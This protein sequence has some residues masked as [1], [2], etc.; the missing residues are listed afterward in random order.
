VLQAYFLNITNL[1]NSEES[2]RVRLVQ[3]EPNTLTS[4][5]SLRNNNFTLLDT[6][7]LNNAQGVFVIDNNPAKP[8]IYRLRNNPIDGEPIGN[9][10]KI[11]S[12]GTAKLAVF[13]EIP[14]DDDGNIDFDAANYE[15]RGHVE[16]EAIGGFSPFFN[17]PVDVLLTPQNRA[18]FFNAG[19]N[20]TNQLQSSLPT[21]DGGA[22]QQ[23]P[24]S[25]PFL[26][27]EVLD[28]PVFSQSRDIKS[29]IDALPK[30]PEEDRTKLL[31]SLLE[32]I[33]KNT[34]DGSIA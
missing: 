18:T 28:L 32:A 3:A 12:R 26:D 1:S 5:R 2:F 20:I 4:N 15:I 30:M 10:I 34:G 14:S 8:D 24:K 21:G 27:I 16:I 23:I 31:T 33:D 13:P 6:S 19:G 22:F 29:I 11:P 17:P 25:G 7:G 9:D